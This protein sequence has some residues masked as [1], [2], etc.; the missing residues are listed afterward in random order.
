[1][2]KGNNL[3]GHNPTEGHT[4]TP[5]ACLQNQVT[6]GEACHCGLAPVQDSPH[7]SRHANRQPTRVGARARA[8]AV[9][10]LI[11]KKKASTA[12]SLAPGRDLKGGS[13]SSATSRPPAAGKQRAVGDGKGAAGQ[14]SSK[15]AGLMQPNAAPPAPP[16]LTKMDVLLR[17]Q[18]VNAVFNK[19]HGPAPG[20]R[21][22]GS[23]GGVQAAAGSSGM[24]GIVG[25]VQGNDG[26]TSGDVL[27]EDGGSGRGSNGS[28]GIG[29]KCNRS[30]GRGEDTN[31]PFGH[32]EAGSMGTTA[33]AP[34][35]SARDMY[36]RLLRQQAQ[37]RAAAYAATPAARFAAAQMLPAHPA[38]R[39]STGG[40]QA[41]ISPP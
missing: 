39:G 28:I 5:P 6:V 11:T 22:R 3:S 9:L 26:G 24:P 32:G 25:A 19:L 15:W 14:D 38:S 34:A 2:L 40:C 4:E 17:L 27:G 29:R 20:E 16:V 35:P 21:G 18:K 37:H 30:C 31:G 41:L 1:M 10:E 7:E 13:S 8:T 33:P 36:V 12:S 23:R